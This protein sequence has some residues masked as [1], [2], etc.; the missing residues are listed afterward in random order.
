MRTR[1]HIDAE[2]IAILCFG[3]AVIIVAIKG[4]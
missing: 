2:S 3:I 4:G 1:I